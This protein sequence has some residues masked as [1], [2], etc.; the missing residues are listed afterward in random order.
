MRQPFCLL[1]NHFCRWLKHVKEEIEAESSTD[2]KTSWAAYHADQIQQPAPSDISSLL[3]LFYEEAKS[4]AMIAHTMKV[5]KNA[6]DFLNP[7]QIPVV[8]CDQPLYAIA[9]QLQWQYPNI[10]GENQVVVMFGGLHIELAFLKVLGDWLEGTGWTNTLV[11]AEIASQG[12][13]DSFLKAAH[14][15]RTRHAHQV[16]AG[17]LYILMDRAYKLHQREDHTTDPLS[18]EQWRVKMENAIPMFNFWSITLDLELAL[19]VFLQSLRQGNF[20]LYKAALTK[21]APWFFALDH[22]NYARWVPVHIR[23]MASLDKMHPEVAAEFLEGKF[24]VHKTQHS[25][26]GI[27]LDQAHEQNNKQVKGDGG[28]VG[29]TENS[30]QLQRWMVAGPE[31]S[32]VVSEFE[33]VVE[34]LRRHGEKQSD[35]RHHEAHRGVQTT[36]RRQV[37]SLCDTLEDM[38]N[39]FMEDSSDLLV[40]GTQDVVDTEIIE[41]VKHIKRVGNEQYRDFVK[42]RLE[43]RTKSLTDPIKRNKFHLF[44]S[45]PTHKSKEK[46]QIASLKQ[47]CSLFSKLYVSCQVR[48]GDIDEFFRHENQ[49]SPPS[50]SQ[51]GKLRHGT[52]ADLL[53]FLTQN[54]TTIKDKPDTDAVLLDGAAIVNMLNPGASRTFQHYADQV[55]VPHVKR[56]LDSARRV[57]I[58]FDRYFQDSLKAT[59]RSL[60]GEGNRRKVKANTPV[61]GNWKAFLRCDANKAELFSFLADQCT[62]VSCPEGKQIMSTK[63][64]LVLCNPKRNSIDQISPCSHEEADTRLLLHA[65]DAVQHGCERIM[66]RTVDTDVVVLAV[67]LYLPIHASE[68]WISFGVGD[69]FK[70][71]PA[72]T[73][74]GSLG[75]KCRALPMFHAFS[76]CDNTS[77]FA[78]KGKK[79]SW[80]TWQICESVTEVF[81]DL[82]NGPTL[83]RIDQHMANLERFVV[84]LYDKTSTSTSADEAR[85]DLF[86]RKGRSIDLIPP[87]SAALYQH[88][89]RASYQ[90]GHVWGQSLLPNPVLPSPAEWGWMKGPGNAWEPYWSDLPQ[91]SVSCMEFLK[92]GC[93]KGCRGRCKCVKAQLACT[94][95]CKCGGD[96]DR[97]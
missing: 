90:A 97:V 57:D 52:K 44:S 84:L 69:N 61:P 12:T 74:A 32:R 2:L 81:A 76:G 25:F 59:A 46:Q 26:S 63:G 89:R 14:I 72:H 85:K 8:A 78:G 67:A 71:I 77:S 79:S 31:V 6:V 92:C 56:Q 16:T 43:D 86:T 96:C 10:H 17:S 13:S 54:G 49:S 50:L 75:P 42:E 40:L 66:I 58:I 15:T 53:P 87:T 73:I 62:T 3:P 18:F 41:T 39:P 64:E 21:L 33:T 30:A 91:A 47:D 45:Q 88:V 37:K 27:P 7:G 5:V 20:N 22:P 19:M 83:E 38:G 65:K 95:L 28:A 70:Y 82:G 11:Q 9:K 48:D 80:E 4:S 35:Q 36:Y 24:V 51:G 94:A 29:L 1:Y 68:L 23:D 34:G 55:F 60:R 93:V